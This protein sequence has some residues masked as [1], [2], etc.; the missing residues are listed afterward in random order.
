MKAMPGSKVYL[1]LSGEP[2]QWYIVV[3]AGTH[4][5]RAQAQRREHGG[6]V[7]EQGAAAAR[8]QRLPRR[9]GHLDAHGRETAASVNL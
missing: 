2:R 9:T 4:S 8:H 3:F 6:C 5:L 1:K 7:A